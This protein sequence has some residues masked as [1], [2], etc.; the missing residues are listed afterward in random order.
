MQNALQ[1]PPTNQLQSLFQH[2]LHCMTYLLAAGAMVCDVLL[3]NSGNM[4]LANVSVSG[5][6]NDCDVALLE[7]RS[8]VHCSMSHTLSQEDYDAGFVNVTANGA[9]ADPLGP[10]SVLPQVLPDTARVVLNQSA[11]LDLSARSDKSYVL[12]AGDSVTVVFTAGNTGS[13][14]LYNATFTISPALSNVSCNSSLAAVAADGSVQL[15]VLAVDVAVSC[16]GLLE[17]NQDRLEAGPQLVSVTGT[18]SSPSGNVTVTAASQDVSI[19][20]V[21]SPGLTLD[22]QPANC[23]LPASAGG[24]VVCPVLVHNS[25]NMRLQNVS[26]AGVSGCSFALLQPDEQQLCQLRQVASQTDFDAAYDNHTPLQLLVAASG[27][28]NGRNSSEVSASAT[29]IVSL[30]SVLHAALQLSNWS[31]QPAVISVAGMVWRVL[32]LW[33]Q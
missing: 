31:I 15:P 14:T 11:S 4:R 27:V 13:V 20:P 23:S 30:Q 24:T 22:L 12:A 7:P 18:A 5:D 8:T 29:E 28:S 26:V 9:S 21:N 17:F 16:S 2:Y 10:V 25:G 19:I 33:V 6:S 32:R 3:F 1:V